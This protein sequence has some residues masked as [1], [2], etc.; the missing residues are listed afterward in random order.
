MMLRR[1]KIVRILDG[2][3]RDVWRREGWRLERQTFHG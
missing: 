1:M 2:W 3:M